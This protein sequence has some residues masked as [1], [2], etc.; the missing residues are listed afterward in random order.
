MIHFHHSLADSSPT[1]SREPYLCD[2]ASTSIPSSPNDT[3]TVGADALGTTSTATIPLDCSVCLRDV[4]QAYALLFALPERAHVITTLI[5]TIQ[6]LVLAGLRHLLVMQQ[7]PAL[8]DSNA[9]PGTDAFRRQQRLVNVFIIL[10]ACPL[11]T[12][13]LH[14]EVIIHFLN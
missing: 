14:F 3:L 6:R 1:G 7:S 9:E 13:P 4:S 2:R 8:R 5:R 10:F 11:V 12:N